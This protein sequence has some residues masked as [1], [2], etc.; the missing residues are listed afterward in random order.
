MAVLTLDDII[1]LK[2]QVQERFHETLHT[3]DTCGGQSFSVRELTPELRSFL[4]DYFRQKGLKP[5]FSDTDGQFV[6]S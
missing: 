4:T 1:Q 2:K 6:V 3:H 5:T